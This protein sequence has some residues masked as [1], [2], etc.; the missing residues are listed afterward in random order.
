MADRIHRIDREG[1]DVLKELRALGKRRAGIEMIFVGEL[2]A[3]QNRPDRLVAHD[4]DA[5]EPL[6][7]RRRA[8]QRRP[9]REAEIR[10]T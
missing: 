5:E 2:L 10:C 3:H 8:C 1:M 7:A 6:T 9:V 4:G